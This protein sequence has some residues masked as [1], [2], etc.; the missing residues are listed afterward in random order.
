MPR[1]ESVTVFPGTRTLRAREHS[2][3]PLETTGQELVLTLSSHSL[4]RAVKSAR[5]PPF[6]V[7]LRLTTPLLRMWSTVPFLTE[8]SSRCPPPLHCVIRDPL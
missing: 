1:F 7:S 2:G 5:F 6:Q 4:S 8:L 3:L